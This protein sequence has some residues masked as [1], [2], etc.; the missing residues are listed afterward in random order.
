[1]KSALDRLREDVNAL[2]RPDEEVAVGVYV[3]DL[4]KALAVIDAA[5]SFRN[6]AKPGISKA[7]DE[8]TET[9]FE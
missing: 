3:K 9:D 4:K 2:A 5:L 8:L 1:M 7:L 6:N